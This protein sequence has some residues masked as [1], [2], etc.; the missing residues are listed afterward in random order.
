MIFQLDA[1]V[2]TGIG[3]VLFEYPI[4]IVLGVIGLRQSVE[5]E[6]LPD[7]LEIKTK[8]VVRNDRLTFDKGADLQPHSV[9]GR[10]V[11]GV[12]G[13]DVVEIVRPVL[14][15]EVV[16]RA[17]EKAEFLHNHVVFNAHKA[18]LADAVAVAGSGFKVDGC[19]VH[20][21]S[22]DLFHFKVSMSEPASF[23]DIYTVFAVEG[24]DD[25]L[26]STG[27]G[28]GI[29]CINDLHTHAFFDADAVADSA[30]FYC[31]II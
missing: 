3:K 25:S 22:V 9:E 10:G 5:I 24:F 12:G 19:E 30:I 18:H 2:T 23:F 26:L 28:E 14:P 1:V 27:V 8:P 4:G 6:S 7:T 17:N 31:Y 29:A 16:R 11:R 20:D 21:A 15:N 13:V